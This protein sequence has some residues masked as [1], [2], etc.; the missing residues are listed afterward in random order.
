GFASFTYLRRLPFDSIK[1]D[2]MFVRDMDTDDVHSGMVRSMAEMGRLLNKP[3]VAECVENERVA[4]MLRALG[5]EWGQGF[6]FH[7]PEALTPAL[8]REWVGSAPAQA[9]GAQKAA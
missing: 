6:V 5:I 8:L 4:A 1:I 3:I 2:G 9:S 7:H